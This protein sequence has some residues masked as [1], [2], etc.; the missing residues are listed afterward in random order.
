MIQILTW[1]ALIAV[2]LCKAEKVLMVA[3]IARHGARGP[4]FNQLPFD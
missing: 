1:L 4:M 2:S 3:Q